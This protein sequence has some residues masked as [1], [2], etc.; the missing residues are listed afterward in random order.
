MKRLIV[1]MGVSGC[2]KST[3]SQSLGQHL[4]ISVIEG[5]DFH[6]DANIQK[7]ARGQPLDDSDR[8]AWLEAVNLEIERHDEP[9]IIL[10]C[11]ALTPFVQTA[12][13]RSKTRM[14]VW[15]WLE[16]SVDL[17]RQRLKARQGHF[18]TA[19]LLDSQFEALRPPKDCQR[20]SIHKSVNDIVDE[21]STMLRWLNQ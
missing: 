11:S 7:M 5:D 21:I 15:I 6:P 1:I 20:V 10:A 12:L 8:K 9:D 17:I 16:G 3:I 18:M 19:A 4:N 14:C 2:G 13:S